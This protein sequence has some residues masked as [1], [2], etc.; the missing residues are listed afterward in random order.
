MSLD[1]SRVLHIPGS[2]FAA[3]PDFREKNTWR[4]FLVEGRRE[5]GWTK[6]DRRD[7]RTRLIETERDYLLRG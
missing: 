2:P 1:G 4:I 3:M 5:I 7:A 6:G